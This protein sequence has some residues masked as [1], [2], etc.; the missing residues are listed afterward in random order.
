MILEIALF[1]IVPGRE[2]AFE[3]AFLEARK[4]LASS[5]GHRAHELLRGHEQPSRYTLLVRWDDVDS[6]TQG[7]RGSVLFTQW[8]AL[9]Q[10]HF[11]EA[12][13]VRHCVPIV[14]E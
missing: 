5:P 4:L 8:R 6:H 12:P 3:T 10:P 2:Q 13:E 14:A 1:D 9:L 11:R 7:F